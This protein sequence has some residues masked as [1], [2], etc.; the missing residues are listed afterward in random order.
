MTLEK[1][2]FIEPR[3]ILSIQFECEKGGTKKAFPIGQ[4]TKPEPLIRCK[5]CNAEWMSAKSEEH[6]ALNQFVDGMARISSAMEGRPFKL[7]IEVPGD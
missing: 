2:Q 1:K 3:D 4:K 7:A 6:D 5:S